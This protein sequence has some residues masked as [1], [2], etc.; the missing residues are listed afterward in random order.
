MS[1]IRI[2]FKAF[3]AHEL[4]CHF[5][6]V[7]AGLYAKENIDV[8]LI[9]ITFVAEA[10]LPKDIFQ[11]SCGA[12]L[13]SALRGIPQR[14]IVVATDRPM[15]WIYSSNK[16]SSLEDLQ[17]S[18]IATFPAIAP[19][20]HLANIILGKHGIDVE[21]EMKLLPARDDAARFGLLGAAYVDAAVLSSA[22]SPVQIEEKGFNNLCF[23]GDEIRIP[24]TG[25]SVD[26]SFIEKKPELIRTIVSIYKNSLSIIA[27]D[28][29][30]VTSVL[31]DYFN[32]E[33]TYSKKTAELFAPCF[34]ANGVT[35][36]TIAQTAIAS[37]CKSLSISTVPDWQQIYTFT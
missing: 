7:T 15:F 33:D 9:D 11:A 28:P 27:S 13:S 29:A 12:A 2:G 1:T 6:A 23:F 5:V 21:Q 16:I 4:L 34:T 36:E 22:L 37:L 31:Q 25:L 35:S 10:D 17:G 3:D 8:E 32:M 24:T 20:H 18:R 14:I 26:Q 30:L 19:P